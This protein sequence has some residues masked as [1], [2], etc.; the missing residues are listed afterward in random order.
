MIP[1]IPTLKSNQQFNQPVLRICGDRSLEGEVRISGSKNAVLPIMAAA[2]LS[3]DECQIRNVPQLEDVTQMGRILE[4]LGVSVE[5]RGSVLNLNSASLSGIKAPSDAVQKLRAG[6]LVI[7]PL[8]ARTG[9]AQVPLPGGCAIGS[10]PVDLHLRGLEAMGAKIEVREGVVHAYL[11]QGDRLQGARI[12]LDFPSVG[13]T[14]ALIMAAVLAEGETVIENAAQEPEVADMIGFCQLMG[15]RISG[16][17]TPRIVISGVSHLHGTEYRVI[18]DRIEAGTF[19]AAAA[20]TRSPLT[21]TSV[22]AAHL[23]SVVEELW[24]MG[25]MVRAEKTPSLETSR[26]HRLRIVP[27]NKPMGR[28]IKTRPY[29][30]FPTDM[31][32]QFM[33]L[34]STANDNSFMIETL[35]ENRFQHIPE[36]NRMGADIRVQGNQALI[37]GGARLVG[38]DVT[39]TDLRAGAALV[40]AAL[41]AEGTTT[42]RNL[43]YLDRGYENLEAKLEMLGAKVERVSPLN[44]SPKKSTIVSP[45]PEEIAASES[46]LSA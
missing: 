11:K 9:M 39:A 29:P 15:A 1:S 3:A 27:A 30:G 8:L 31:Q 44:P 42:I 13:A 34:L 20:I 24:A 5:H 36:L 35:F 16:A 10:R 6:F 43:H 14:E 26:L 17:G 21:L 28:V 22:N 33:S 41:A 37:F 23:R 40:L 12:K 2:L 46:I 38:T 18:P 4:Y 25:A 19:L 7:A 32:P 45:L